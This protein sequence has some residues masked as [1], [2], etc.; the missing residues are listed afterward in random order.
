MADLIIIT[1][2]KPLE[3]LWFDESEDFEQLSRRI[4]TRIEVKEDKIYIDNYDPKSKTIKYV[5]SIANPIKELIKTNKKSE[6]VSSFTHDWFKD[7]FG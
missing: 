1:S 7:N 5:T 6:Q 3:D 4:T 2:T